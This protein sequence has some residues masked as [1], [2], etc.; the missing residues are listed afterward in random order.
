MGGVN[1]QESPEEGR[2]EPVTSFPMTPHHAVVSLAT[3]VKLQ[4]YKSLFA[5][6]SSEKE[7][8][9]FFQKKTFAPWCSIFRRIY[10]S[11]G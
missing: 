5:S 1:Q 10:L 11:L 6:F 9:S 3:P 4:E 2:A 7:D 8:S